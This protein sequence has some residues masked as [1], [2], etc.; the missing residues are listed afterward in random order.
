MFACKASLL[1]Q[2]ATKPSLLLQLLQDSSS[3]SF[4]KSTKPSLLVQKNLRVAALRATKRYLVVA[5]LVRRVVATA[6]PQT[7]AAQNQS[8]PSYASFCHCCKSQVGLRGQTHRLDSIP[9]FETVN[10]TLCDTRA[11]GGRSTSA[12]GRTSQ[13]SFFFDAG[14]R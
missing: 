10:S 6:N 7:P 4:G 8:L 14:E 1:L 2:P 3:G 5:F 13:Q 11:L 12:W 9:I